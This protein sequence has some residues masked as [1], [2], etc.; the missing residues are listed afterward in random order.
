[1]TIT[2]TRTGAAFVAGLFLFTACERFPGGA[3]VPQVAPSPAASTTAA[4]A[5]VGAPGADVRRASAGLAEHVA[6]WDQPQVIGPG[7]A[8]PRTDAAA[9][10]A[11][12]PADLAA[13]TAAL[14]SFLRAASAPARQATPE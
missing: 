1:M 8:G 6:G 2:R 4:A 11:A 13:A 7:R 3:A 14:E 12:S 5:V 9:L 10:R